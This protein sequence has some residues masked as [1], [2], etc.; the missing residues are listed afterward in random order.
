MVRQAST[1]TITALP[2]R[3][4]PFPWEDLASLTSRQAEQMGYRN[5]TWILRPEEVPYI[6][7]PFSL[8]QLRDKA[9]Y[10]FFEQLLGLDE[11]CLYQLTLHRFASCL[12]SPT[13]I[14]GAV[15]K[16]INRPLLKRY[17]FQSFF[18][19]Y[20]ATKVCSR[21]LAEEPGY[22][23]LY[24]SALPVVAC[25]QHNIFLIDACP[26][27]Q[28]PI[29]ALRSPLT[30]CPRCKSGDYRDAPA[31]AFPGDVM[32]RAGQ[33]LLL[34]RLGVAVT[35]QFGIVAPTSPLLDLQPHHYFQLFD[36][37]HHVLRPLF[38]DAPF[39]R[40]APELRALLHQRQRPRGAF[41]PLEW[42]VFIATFHALF[43]SWPDAF[44]TFLDTFPQARS[45]RARKRDQERQ[46]G[47]QR[48]YGVFYERWLYKRLADSAFSFL[49]E[50]FEDYLKRR[51]TGG[52]ITHRL[53]PFK[54]RTDEQW[55]ERTYLTKA[56][57]RAALG[58]GE[59]VLQSLLGQG[60]LRAL[61]K[62][63][64]GTKRRSMF[65]VDRTSVEALQREW[66]A[67]I[68]LDIVA[69]SV[70]G[71]TKAVVLSLEQAGML[72][73]RRGPHQDGYK[74]RLY[75]QADIVQFEKLLL[76][77]V[78]RV[79]ESPTNALPLPKAS[80]RMGMALVEIL[81]EVLDNHLTLLEVSGNQP[82]FRRLV[83]PSSQIPGFLQEYKRG[84]YRERGLLTISEAA[85][86]IG[87]GEKVL[88]RWARCGLVEK[89]VLVIGGK[90]PP[91]LFRREAVEAFRRTYAFVNEVADQLRVMPQTVRKYVQMG[92]LHP[93]KDRS[94]GEWASGL[95]FRRDE[96]EEFRALRGLES[97]EVF[98]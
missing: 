79:S 6:V 7:Q 38:P 48:D 67:L 24:W 53:L 60:I 9:D 5:P 41:S 8:C 61:R 11:E 62:P 87:V 49:H 95:I 37:F 59:D 30:K 83:L 34:G 93:V 2:I 86:C 58:I 64:G 36:A 27:C 42:S 97:D 16:E 81:R 89:E 1:Q 18:H 71:V 92:M 54:E 70:L 74:V 45:G 73:P 47:V 40:V 17:T 85:C 20:S 84:Q 19:P 80:N 28:R 25:L 75:S 14:D 77:R 56:Q 26:S 3:T 12:Q 13:T 21:C 55:L 46:T 96:I 94:T 39:L 63:L 15:A 68:P 22:G 50:A 10:C 90:Q 4:I 32:L 98:H 82:L 33:T 78:R 57:V 52:E 51:Y 35:N 29:P 88:R 31:A 76:P 65:L 43:A 23:R 66:S 72:T 91:L 44:F 69:K